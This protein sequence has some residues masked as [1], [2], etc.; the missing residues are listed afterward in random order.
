VLNNGVGPDDLLQG[1]YLYLPAT[2][3]CLAVASL[4][5]TAAAAPR[6][7]SPWPGWRGRCWRAAWR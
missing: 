6:A 3:Y 2:G 5:Y 4:L 1:R 7:R